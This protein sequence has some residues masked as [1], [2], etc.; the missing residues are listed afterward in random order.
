MAI[1]ILHYYNKDALSLTSFLKKKKERNVYYLLS[2]YE[3]QK[4]VRE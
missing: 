1:F 2:T 4:C 3:L